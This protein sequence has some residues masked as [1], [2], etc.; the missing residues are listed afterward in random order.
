MMWYLNAL[1]VGAG[2]VDAGHVVV[3]TSK[4]TA[5]QAGLNEGHTRILFKCRALNL[6]AAM[7]ELLMQKAGAI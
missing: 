6:T 3:T 2:R 7:A 1:N 4:S 5:K